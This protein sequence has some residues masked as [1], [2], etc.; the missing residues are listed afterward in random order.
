[1][2]LGKLPKIG[3]TITKELFDTL[4]NK[5][6]IQVGEKIPASQL[7]TGAKIVQAQQP[8]V[9]PQPQTFGQKAL[10]VAKG[11]FDILGG[12]AAFQFGR[13]PTDVIGTALATKEQQRVA[14]SRGS[15]ADI[16]NRL[17][18]RLRTL[19]EG[20]QRERIK[21]I[22]LGN[23]K[24]MNLS[25]EQE[26]E[27]EES[28][29][30]P[31]QAVGRTA[32]A[33][34]TAATAA[35]IGTGAKAGDILKAPIG[36]ALKAI[37]RPLIQKVAIGA[38]QAAG[39]TAA[40]QLAEEGKIDKGR[41]AT[42]AAIGGAFPIAIA[43]AGAL[44]RQV[45]QQLPRR[46]I[47]TAIKQKPKE[48]LSRKDLTDFVIKKKKIGTSQ[49]LIQSSQ[50][51]ISELS[52]EISGKIATVR[53]TVSPKKIARQIA[54]EINEAGG[55]ITADEVLDIVKKL[56]PQRKG[57]LEKTVIGLTEANNIRS[58][59]DRTLGDRGF[60]STQLTFNKDILRKYT[61][62]LRETVKTR[63][64]KIVRGLFDNLSKEIRLRD[65]LLRKITRGQGNQILSFGDLIGGGLGAIVGGVPGVFIGAGIRRGIQSTPFLTGAGVGLGQL[66][67]AGQK[68]QP[69]LQKLPSTQ[70]IIILNAISAAINQGTTPQR[71]GQE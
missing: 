7:P 9:Q 57:L 54:N 58:G 17:L 62:T 67:I 49:G 29:I 47:Q 2:A 34:I 39:F 61:N 13:L 4:K 21:K 46:F 33:A 8:Q 24:Q 30:T 1:M 31:K 59:I 19:P 51:A 32:E 3:E 26:K 50:K 20:E 56:A 12:R 38:G 6:V 10:G 43:G 28:I 37:K 42:G 5:K 22:A 63:A 23:I 45:T 44:F 40:R 18:K 41:V 27:L 65:T 25:K 14:E 35:R 71:Q 69:L 15:L 64:P 53:G 68:L 60:L 16:T 70:R 55:S 11:A 66:G 48:L 52:D 36:T